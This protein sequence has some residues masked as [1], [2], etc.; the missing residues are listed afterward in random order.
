M[1][2]GLLVVG[3]QLVDHLLVDCHGSSYFLLPM[4]VYT[5]LFTPSRAKNWNAAA[6]AGTPILLLTDLDQHP[7]PLGL[8]EGWLDVEPHANLIFRVAVRELNL[9]FSPIARASRSFSAL[10]MLLYLCNLIRYLT[11]NNLLST[12]LGDHGPALCGNPSF[13]ARQH[14]GSGPGL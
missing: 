5:V 9:G 6:A 4:A 10:V 7:C 12:W 14:C 13:R 8:I 1:N 2:L 3:E 11:Q